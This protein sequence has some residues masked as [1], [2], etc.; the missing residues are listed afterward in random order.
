MFFNLSGRRPDVRV[1]AD[2][3]RRFRAWRRGRPFWAGLFTLAASLPIVYFPYV[4]LTVAGV[5]LALSTTAGAGALII[6]ILLMVLGIT[7]WFQQ[8]V[9]VFAGIAA[10]LLTLVSFP[11]ANFGGLFLGLFSGL[12]G[13][14]LA[15]AW[16]PPT[17]NAEPPNRGSAA[18][19][20]GEGQGDK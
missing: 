11:V 6:G 15:C 9:R 17:G 1:A 18:V 13:G 19:P 16:A 4:H 2:A 10:L 3:R 7:L 5:P 14:S 20:V 8:Q 12:I